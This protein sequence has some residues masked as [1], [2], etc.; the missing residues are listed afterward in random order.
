VRH[1]QVLAL[2]SPC[3]AYQN[4]GVS[5]SEALK[6][7]SVILIPTCLTWVPS[8]NSAK[9]TWT[10]VQCKIHPSARFGHS[11]VVFEDKVYLFGGWDGKYTLNDLWE[12]DPISMKWNLILKHCSVAPRYR[13]SA[14][15]YKNFMVIFG[16]VDSCQIR[17]NDIHFYN[18]GAKVWVRVIV[19]GQLPTPRTFHKVIHTLTPIGRSD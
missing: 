17:F 5:Y 15:C 16:G 3:L 2:T 18:F 12:F 4:K 13:H 11:Q 14:V 9:S 8:S 1:H 6:P 10:E 19:P 7:F